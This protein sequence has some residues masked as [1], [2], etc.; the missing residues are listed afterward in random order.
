RPQLAAVLLNVLA[1]GLGP[2]D[3]GCACGKPAMRDEQLAALEDLRLPAVALAVEPELAPHRRAIEPAH[4]VEDPL[5]ASGFG[6]RRRF[7]VRT[8]EGLILGH[9]GDLVQFLRLRTRR[10][11]G[12]FGRFGSSNRPRVE[13]AFS[14]SLPSRR[15]RSIFWNR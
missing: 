7:V 10:R 14:R 11:L 12:T 2:G 9:R 8:V 13:G 15:A 1:L 5:A 6:P 3:G 4:E